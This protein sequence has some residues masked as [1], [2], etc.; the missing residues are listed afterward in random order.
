MGKFTQIFSNKIIFTAALLIA[1]CLGVWLYFFIREGE[2]KNS[3]DAMRAIP[4]DAAF[5]L[6]VNDLNQLTRKLE[7]EGEIAQLMRADKSVQGLHAT[8]RYI[9]DTMAQRNISVG[10][11]IQQPLWVSAHVFGT[12]LAFLYSLNLPDNLYLS[13]VKQLTELLSELGYTL[14]EQEYDDEKIATFRSA[15]VEMFHASLVRRVLVI[16]TSRVLVEMAIRQAKS[17]ASLADDPRFVQASQAAGA[18]VDANLYV[19][20]QQLPRLM[21]L[22]L[23]GS[24]GKAL[25]FLSRIG[26]FTMLDADMRADALHLNGFLFSDNFQSSYLS[27]LVGQ[28]SQPLTSFDMLPRTTDAALCLGISNAQLLLNRCDDFRERQQAG[29]SARQEKLKQLRKVLGKEAA[30]FF[31]SLS[32][33]ELAVAHVP[34]TGVEEK[35]TRFILLKSGRADAARTTLQNAVALAAKA[36]GK[37]EK[38]FVATESMG[39]GEP[40]QVYQ[41]VAQGL[42]ASLM[43][44]LFSACDDAYF[45]FIGDYVV[46]ASS[47]QALREFA[48]AALLKKTLAQSVDLSE[49]T[50]SESNV[51][52]YVNPAKGD[53]LAQGMLKPELQKKIKKSPLLAASHGAGM[54]LRV[55][56]DKA[57]CNAFFKVAPKVDEKQQRQSGLR[58]AFEAKL[59]VPAAATP[60][61]VKNH[62]NGQ[63]EL[64]VQD[65]N[66]NLYLID[67]QGVLL[68]K[69]QLDEPVMGSVR[70]VDYLKNNKLQL[71]FNTK[72]KLYL[73]DR[74]GRNVEK[75]PLALA[76]PAT[77]PVAIFD[78]DRSRDY[79]YFVPC[80]DGKI[81][82]YESNGKP[83]TG[84]APAA[85]FGAI[86]QT[87][88]HVR[89][90]G[91]DYIVV[92]DSR[93]IHL[94]NR[95]GEEREQLKERVAPARH[96]GLFAE[97]SS[98][99]EVARL[100]TTSSG[101]ELV[102][103]YFDGKVERTKLKPSVDARHFFTCTGKSYVILDDKDLRVY[104]PSLKLRFS[105]GFRHAPEDAPEVFTPLADKQYYGVYVKD[106]QRAYLL[107]ASGD[108]LN[109]FPVKAVVPLLVDNLRA[110]RGSFSVVVCDD[111]GFLSCYSVAQ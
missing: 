75:F 33:V 89:T 63:K 111:N 30:V 109:N 84:F 29:G 59:E 4:A 94:L 90:R 70:Q 87:P 107:N 101:G 54:Q 77:A 96:S 18:H 106:E 97:Q 102:F 47:G 11:L 64:L 71:L 76:A 46:Y 37:Q 40:L 5:V 15:E 21:P 24:Y 110:E 73:L 13:D 1:L 86:T 82:A 27:T 61:V 81:R 12:E 45:T 17:P 95:R 25:G 68:W 50:T 20:H 93:T 80:S 74:L 67:N 43:G 42:V 48:L 79:R 19:N 6:R 35:D 22:F 60:W 14:R 103:V 44:D 28:K 49:Y 66:N 88:M 55:M 65:V 26:S 69:K 8:L 58:L 53:G 16:S 2:K 100:V 78:Y 23:N 56:S 108:V 9:V 7:S 85:D 34:M 31:A 104:E 41:N 38:D 3:M 39:N 52:I 32:P 10:D 92:P 105:Y 98:K 99:G 72:T 62:K 36:A 57:Y 51:L 91:N 83:L